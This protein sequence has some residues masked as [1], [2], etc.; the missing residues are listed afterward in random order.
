MARASGAPARSL[1]LVVGLL[2]SRPVTCAVASQAVMLD[3][4]AIAHLCAGLCRI[5]ARERGDRA[6]G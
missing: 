1:G 2:A 6:C 5:Y 4:A 3:A